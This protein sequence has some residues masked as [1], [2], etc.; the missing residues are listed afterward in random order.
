MALW[1]QLIQYAQRRIVTLACVSGFLDTSFVPLGGFGL[2]HV[3]KEFSLHL[4]PA[5]M[6]LPPI[7]EPHPVFPWLRP[8]A[9]SPTSDPLQ[10]IRARSTA[11][12]RQQ[13]QHP[14]LPLQ[15]LTMHALR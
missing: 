15:S 7:H 9:A 13:L 5:L 8:H 2:G 11:F 14:M 1:R 12:L 4:V 10:Q 3:H 6:H